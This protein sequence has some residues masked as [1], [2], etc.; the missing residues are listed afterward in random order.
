MSQQ[1]KK[2]FKTYYVATPSA[3]KRFK[4]WLTKNELTLQEFAKQCEVSKAYISSVM[5]GK[6]HI[7][8]KTRELFEKAGYKLL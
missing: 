7:T 2:V 3:L 4:V 5:H 1:V 6:R 8:K